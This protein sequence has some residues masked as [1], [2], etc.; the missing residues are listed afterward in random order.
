MTEEGLRELYTHDRTKENYNIGSKLYGM[1]VTGFKNV[2]HVVLPEELQVASPVSFTPDCI[3]IEVAFANYVAGNQDYKQYCIDRVCAMYKGSTGHFSSY[4]EQ[5]IPAMMEDSDYTI[6]NILSDKYIKT[7]V[8]QYETDEILPRSILPL[9]QEQ[10]GY[11][12]FEHFSNI[13]NSNN[14][15]KDEQER[16]SADVCYLP[17]E[18]YVEKYIINPERAITFQLVFPNISNFDS[19]NP[20]LWNKILKNHDDAAWLSKFEVN[21]GTN[22]QTDGTV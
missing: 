17:K 1:G 18:E 14:I 9:L 15:D 12:H 2:E 3:R 10:F 22:N 6:T 16:L 4:I 11:N 7:I 13:I 5:N 20:I 21:Y 8:D 19:I